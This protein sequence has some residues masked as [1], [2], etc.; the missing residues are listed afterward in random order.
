MHNVV[1]LI[2][3]CERSIFKIRRLDSSHRARPFLFNGLND[4]LPLKEF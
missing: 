4:E 1:L 2:C 3:N